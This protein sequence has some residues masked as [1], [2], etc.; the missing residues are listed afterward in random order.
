MFEY[1]TGA[2]RVKA[3]SSGV[4]TSE[5]GRWVMKNP[6]NRLLAQ[7]IILACAGNRIEYSVRPVDNDR[8]RR[9][10]GPEHR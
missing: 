6:R 4:R 3:K 7:P 2:G 10:V 8:R 5:L 9:N 1:K